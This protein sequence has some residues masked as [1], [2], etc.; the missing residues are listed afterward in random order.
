M[1]KFVL[2]LL[3]IALLM[4]SLTL[5]AQTQGTDVIRYGE[6]RH[7]VRDREGMVVS[8]N[9]VA[10]EVGAR[11]LADGGTAVDAAVAV[12][13]ALAVLRPRAGNIGGGGFMLIYSAE[14]GETSAIDYREAA[15]RRASR[16]MFLDGQGN[17][18]ARRARFSHLS[19]GV[20][21]TVA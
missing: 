11:V 20:P 2:Y 15:P 21:G 8:A 5:F 12:G 13:F 17:V 1:K 4:P 9:I 16:D 6:V 3:A 18:D 7:P 10:S 14:D 19:S